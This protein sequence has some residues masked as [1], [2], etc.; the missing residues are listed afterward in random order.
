MDYSRWMS[1][2]PKIHDKK[3]AGIVSRETI[4]IETANDCL[5]R[6][7]RAVAD[8]DRPGPNYPC[9]HG[10]HERPVC[11]RFGKALSRE[12]PGWWAVDR[13]YTTW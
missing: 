3:L 8:L 6:V 11:L 7:L 2:N 5:A 9:V 12:A 13:N 4:A 10:S 1:L